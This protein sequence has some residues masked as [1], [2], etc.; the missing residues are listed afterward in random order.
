MK[1]M[2]VIKTQNG[3][4]VAPYTGPV[5]D[6]FVEQMSVATAIKSFSF[7]EPTVASSLMEFFEPK[8]EVQQ[9]AA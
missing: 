9:E 7:G 4:A 3:F 6:D 1:A 2:L 5:P 8:P